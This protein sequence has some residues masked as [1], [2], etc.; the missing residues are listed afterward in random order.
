[1]KKTERFP[2]NGFGSGSPWQPRGDT[3]KKISLF[4]PAFT[5]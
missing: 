3:R 1:M 2:E 4:G 5:G